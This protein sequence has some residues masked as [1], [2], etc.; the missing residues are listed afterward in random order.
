MGMGGG[1]GQLGQ[2]APPP[3]NLQEDL[4]NRSIWPNNNLKQF[5]V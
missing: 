2:M 3:P 5:R 1:G 4:L